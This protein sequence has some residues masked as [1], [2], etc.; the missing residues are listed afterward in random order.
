[1]RARPNEA[2]VMRAPPTK[3][4]VMPAQSNEAGCRGSGLRRDK[5]EA[6]LSA[7]HPKQA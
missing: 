6:R 1:M 7:R 2:R 3:A 4:G 5:A